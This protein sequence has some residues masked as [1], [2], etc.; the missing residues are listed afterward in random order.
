MYKKIQK[1]K[2]KKFFK[3]FLNKIKNFSNKVNIYQNN[4][5]LIKNRYI[6]ADK[7]LNLMMNCKYL[8][9]IKFKLKIF[10]F[11]FII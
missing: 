3:I 9:K 8:I 4:L 11:E 10:L 6:K 1:V 2:L 5:I 7:N